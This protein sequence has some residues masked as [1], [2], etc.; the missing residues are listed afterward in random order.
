MSVPDSENVEGLKLAYLMSRFPKITETF[1]LYE[2]LE[3]GR[4]GVEVEVFP[5]LRE[6]QTVEH[7]EA[8]ALVRRAHYEQFVSPAILATNAA[9]VAR[10][11]RRYLS[12]MGELLGR[13]WGNTNFFL[14]ALAY[15]PKA[16]CFAR[17]MVDTGVTHI[18]A[19]F[20][21]H[22]TLVAMA[23]HRLTGIPFSFTA[24][25]SDI[26]K[27]QECLREKIEA[28]AFVVT[29]S[30]Y[31]REFMIECCG[32]RYRDKIHI[33]HCGVDPDVFQP[34]RPGDR[35]DD[36]HIVCVASYEEVKGHRYLVEACARLRDQ[37][38]CFVCDLVGEGPLRKQVV[39]HIAEA[40]L[41]DHIRVH[42]ALPRA[43]VAATMQRADVAVLPSVL[44][45]RG[46][47]EGI[48]VVLM[49]A[50]ACGL[51]VVASRISGIPELVLHRRTG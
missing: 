50:M 8:A 45:D 28:A 11:P 27:R 41:G 15:F 43:Q 29:V 12:T 51:P 33:V 13:T 4:R 16:V 35:H 6:R 22:P 7:Q 14:G 47:R 23:V 21:N 1:V 18:H 9:E 46:D 34:A 25:G 37:G 3:L 48:P 49:E 10:S 5:L 17:R 30:E 24:H 36:F 31:D 32:E 20:A 38:V 26:H 42:G 40:G 39:A 44:T 2:I 19:H